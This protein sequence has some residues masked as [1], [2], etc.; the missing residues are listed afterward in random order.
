[1]ARSQ[2]YGHTPYT[3]PRT[4]SQSLHALLD[5]DLRSFEIQQTC[6]KAYC[7]I[8]ACLLETRYMVTL[9]VTPQC[10]SVVISSLAAIMAAG[11]MA[12]DKDSVGGGC[13][14]YWCWKQCTK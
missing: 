2:T 1:M 7:A 8:C 14:V 6:S 12:L 5:I 10:V 11:L 9:I 3:I 13:A 4:I